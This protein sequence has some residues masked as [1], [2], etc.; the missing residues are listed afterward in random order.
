MIPG[1][2]AN[3]MPAGGGAPAGDPYFANVVLLMHGDGV[4][5][6]TATV[7]SSSFGRAITSAGSVLPALSNAQVK[8]G[9]TSMAF[10]GSG[11]SAFTAAASA[12]FAFGT[13]DFTV[14][15]WM[16]FNSFSTA[17]YPVSNN[18]AAG[19]TGWYINLGASGQFLWG[20]G[21][22]ATGSANFGFV[23]LS[24]WHHI[25]F[26]RVGGT[27]RC[28]VDGVQSGA[29]VSHT[30]NYTTSTRA[31]SVGRDNTSGNNVNGYIDD[32]RITKGVGR[33]SANFTPPSA[34]FPN[35]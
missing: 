28:F 25:A 19:G 17:P 32:L 8:F 2:V 5:G 7:D 15:F 1:V 16:Y 10:T 6:A 13:G 20:W 24:G 3:Q 33:Y 31:L 30:V 9:P 29:S 26:S 35:S 22:D 34:A 4:N 11:N 23:A 12:D 27:L 14:E 21:G 18:S